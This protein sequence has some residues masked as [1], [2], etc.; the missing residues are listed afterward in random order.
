MTDS[1][2]RT[3]MTSLDTPGAAGRR[4]PADG[5]LDSDPELTRRLNALLHPKTIA[6]IGASAKPGFALGILRNLLRCGYPGRI[7]PINPTYRDQAILDLPCLPALADV[8]EAV[9]FALLVVPNRLVFEV[10]DECEAKQVGAVNIITSGFGEI[11]DGAGAEAQER[12]TAWAR[13]TGIR[14]VGPNCL[15]N[16]SVPARMAA[17]TGG[18]DRLVPGPIGL[19]MQSGLLATSVSLPCQDRGIGFTYIVTSGNEADLEAADFIRYFV[20]DAGTRVIGCFIEQFRDPGKLLAVAEL[21]ADRRKPIV[22]LK[23]GRSEKGGQVARAHTGS[24]VGSDALIDAVL[25]QR[26]LVRVNTLDEMIETLAIFHAPRLPRGPGVAAA[27]V[28]GGAA[29]LIADL[30]PEVGVSFPDLSPHTAAA[31]RKAIPPYGTV[32]NPL[33]YTGQAAQQPSI[34]EGSLDAL[35]QDPNIHVILYGRSIPSKQD[36]KDPMGQILLRAAERYPETVFVV[37]SLVA[38]AL[39]ESAFPERPNQE[40]YA[41][42]GGIPFLQGAENGL[43]AV[44]AL[45]RYG[46]FLRA[47][48]ARGPRPTAVRPSEVAARARAL[49]HA[50]NGRPLTEGEGKALLALYGIPTARA[51][52]ATTPQEARAA[53]REIGYPVVLKVE[54]PQIL[55]KTEAGAVLLNVRDEEALAAGFDE[56]LAN[57]RQHSPQADIWGVSVQEMA[58]AGREVIL[59]MTRDAQFGPGIML[60]L[61]GIFVGT[62]KDVALFPAPVLDEDARAMLESLKGYP[63]LRGARGTPPA[64]LSAL[65][66]ALLKFSQLCT[67]LM[68]HVREIDI[69]PLVVFENGRGAKALDCLVIPG[70]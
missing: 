33:D 20:E 70:P 42:L 32:G 51:L 40:P 5:S 63:I 69:N 25:R 55:H 59:G 60:G 22:V 56:V 62:L 46:A 64:D 30:G 13:R 7:Y 66:D 26:G 27:L 16:V 37:L 61:G 45:V 53:A 10:L 6:L 68:D 54:S 17:T 35:A 44:A 2:R 24:L 67:D 12:V 3:V 31:I 19:V 4:R 49:V 11:E 52:L 48:Q 38:G 14:V 39:R 21:A 29:G 15:G 50:A 57:A 34:L 18:Y 8:P 28:S 41:F 9:D 43:R 65:I 58:P 1:I 47:R 23:I 36:A